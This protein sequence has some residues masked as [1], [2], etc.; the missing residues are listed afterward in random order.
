MYI[1]LFNEIYWMYT[2]WNSMVED[3]YSLKT[4]LQLPPWAKLQ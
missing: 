4:L 3:R 2:A 1:I